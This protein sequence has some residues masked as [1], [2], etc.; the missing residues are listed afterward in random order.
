MG[1]M[2]RRL[3]IEVGMGVGP[4]GQENNRASKKL[5]VKGPVAR[6]MTTI[7]YRSIEETNF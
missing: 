5:G 7:V 4:D 2:L 3:I 1:K 6:I